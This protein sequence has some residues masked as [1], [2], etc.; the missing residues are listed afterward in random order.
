MFIANSLMFGAIAL[1]LGLFLLPL[2]A[3]ASL[4][5]YFAHFLV[6]FKYMTLI[7]SIRFSDECFRRDWVQPILISLFGIGLLGIVSGF[8]LIYVPDGSNWLVALL[9]EFGTVLSRIVVTYLFAAT[10]LLMLSS[11]LSHRLRLL[12]YLSERI[13]TIKIQTPKILIRT[14]RVTSI[15]PMI[16]LA[17]IVL[18]L[19]QNRAAK[20]PPSESINIV[21]SVVEPVRSAES[22]DLQGLSAVQITLETLDTVN[23]HRALQPMYF[24]IANQKGD[25]DLALRPLQ[26]LVDG[27]QMTALAASQVRRPAMLLTLFF[28]IP[29]SLESLVESQDIFLWYRGVVLGQLQIEPAAGAL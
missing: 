17:L 3:Y 9:A 12:P 23:M 13:E 25:V 29:R 2:A 28:E 21:S 1:M 24:R 10:A 26:V 18:T 27:E 7:E 15:T 14:F 8:V 6:C 4:K 11:D 16:F 20:M 22:L 19:N 5:Y